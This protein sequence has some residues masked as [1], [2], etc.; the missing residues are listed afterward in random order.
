MDKELNHSLRILKQK[1]GIS[2][3]VYSSAFNYLQS[4]GERIPFSYEGGYTDGLQDKKQN[5]TLFRFR[6]KKDSY[7]GVIRGS[8]EV[9]RNYAM[10]ICG[11][12]EN[13]GM[14]D[15]SLSKTDFLRGI[16][17]GECSNMQIVK[18]M[19][20]FAVPA[21][22]CYI[23]YIVSETP[24]AEEVSYFLENYTMNGIDTPFVENENTCIFVKYLTSESDTAFQSSVEYAEIFRRSLFEETGIKVKIG[25]GGIARTLSDSEQS[26]NQAES[27]IKISDLFNLK[28]PV[29]SHKEFILYKMLED[30]PPSTLANY[31][32]ILADGDA[33]TVFSDDDLLNTAE[34]FL[35]NNLNVSETARKLY[36]HRNTLT[37]RL[38]KIERATGL[39]IR[40]FSDAI[41]LRICNLLYKLLNK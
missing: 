22:P 29:H 19:R 16:V 34:E 14:Q 10:F 2:I 15:D 21:V 32:N 4:S 37:Y 17:F 6:F 38:D 12:L 35:E 39:D 3:D 8:S 20:K 24:S 36:M 41:T 31:Y 25:V 13:S 7:Y 18:Y 26:L 28:N 5:V 27:A 40:N 30:L 11:H 23:L 33:K 1:T 9:E